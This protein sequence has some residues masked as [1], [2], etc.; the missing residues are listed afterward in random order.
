MSELTTQNN[1][2]PLSLSLGELDLSNFKDLIEQAKQSES[3]IALTEDFG[4]GDGNNLWRAHVTTKI[5]KSDR[6]TWKYPTTS[7]ER[8][9]AANSG[10]GLYEEVSTSAP[11]HHFVGLRGIVLKTGYG[12]ALGYEDSNKDYK[13]VCHTTCLVNEQ[14]GVTVTDRLPLEVPV[15]YINEYGEPHKIN[16]WFSERP[17][18][19]MHGSRPPVGLEEAKTSRVRTCE[20][21]VAAGEH[22]IGTLDEYLN[23]KAEIPK[24]TMNGYLLF[25]VFQIG[26]LDS[27][28]VLKGGKAQVKWV[29]I[30]DAQLTAKR[31]DGTLVPRTTPFIIKIEGLT[32]V[33]HYPVG[34]GKKQRDIVTSG[35]SCYLPEGAKLHTWG[36][37]HKKYLLAKNV[38][39]DIRALSLGGTTVYPVVTDLYTAKLKK[40][41]YGATHIGV[42]TPVLDPDV[43]DRGE[44]LSQFDWLQAALQCLQYEESV[45][46]GDG[47]DS[48]NSLPGVAPTPNTP[49]GPTT[50]SAVKEIEQEQPVEST[51][52]KTNFAAFAPPPSVS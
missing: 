1:A 19:K 46:K 6:I 39:G 49:V 51:A 14:T 24:C 38:S 47:G 43:I 8:K 40:E 18:L 35:K 30:E 16:K 13:T 21:C 45:V 2:A 25:C 28:Q 7:A 12:R 23:P 27:S 26:V 31:L 17:Y 9:E 33:Q 3:S 22:Y 5:N 42:Y 15:P 11:E 41:E 20:E 37:Y 50:S 48:P 29:D 36:E 44:G 4:T 32:S 10:E 34:S 52:P